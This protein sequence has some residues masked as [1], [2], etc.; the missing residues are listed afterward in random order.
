MLAP[1]N[2]HG[3][4][5]RGRGIHTRNHPNRLQQAMASPPGVV[6]ITTS[7]ERSLA[8]ESVTHQRSDELGLVVFIV[9]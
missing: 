5:Q 4:I 8:K 9:R 7:S 3:M 2:P 6:M 1:R